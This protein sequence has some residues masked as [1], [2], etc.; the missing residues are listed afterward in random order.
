MLRFF[1]RAGIYL[2]W[3]LKVGKRCEQVR[4]AEA[5]SAARLPAKSS[6]NRGAGINSQRCLPLLPLVFL[7]NGMKLS[8]D[9][10]CSCVR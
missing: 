2:S 10:I 9:L 8:K 6:G 7:R 3:P 5:D 1:Y 4:E